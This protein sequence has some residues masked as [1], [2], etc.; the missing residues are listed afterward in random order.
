MADIINFQAY[1]NANDKEKKRIK[2]IL[3][4]S[5][6]KDYI[7]GLLHNLNNSI[8]ISLITKNFTELNQVISRENTIGNDL[9]D[10]IIAA[11]EQYGEDIQHEIVNL[12]N[13]NCVI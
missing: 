1:V 2:K 13:A 4:L 6:K 11:I 9:L 10:I 12:E 3:M 5:T 8:E 7:L